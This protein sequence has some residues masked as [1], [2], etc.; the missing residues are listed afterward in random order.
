MKKKEIKT[1]WFVGEIDKVYEAIEHYNKT[2]VDK[3]HIEEMDRDESFI[4]LSLSYF[5]DGALLYL[6]IYLGRAGV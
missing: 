4:F 5:E 1:G 6:G 3:I 2:F